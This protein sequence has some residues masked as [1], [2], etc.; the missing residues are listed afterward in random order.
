MEHRKN[1]HARFPGR[2]AARR[3][4]AMSSARI[5]IATLVPLF[6]LSCDH[7]VYKLTVSTEKDT[8][9]RELKLY[10]TDHGKSQNLTERPLVSKAYAAGEHSFKD[11]LHV[12]T[13]RFTGR[14]PQDI[15]GYGSFTRFSC[16]YGEVGLY[17]ER[18][19]GS[20]D[21]AANIA[22]RF[23]AV[24]RLTNLLLEWVRSAFGKSPDLF[25]L[26]CFIDSELRRDLKNA[27]VYAFLFVNLPSLAPES[28]HRLS[29]GDEGDGEKTV[30]AVTKAQI[31]RIAERQREELI[32]RLAFFFMERGYLE[33]CTMQYL[34]DLEDNIPPS[35]R[36]T[37]ILRV[38]E[39]AKVSDPAVRRKLC[40]CVADAN[41]LRESMSACLVK[42]P[43]YRELSRGKDVPPDPL[44]VPKNYFLQALEIN[45]ELWHEDDRVLLTVVPAG[46]VIRT[47]GRYDREKNVVTWRRDMGDRDVEPIKRRASQVCWALWAR[48]DETVQ[49]KHFGK[50]AIDGEDLLDYCMWHHRLSAR[51]RDEWDAFLE[52]LPGSAGTFRALDDFRFS[53]EPATPLDENG[54]PPRSRAWSGIHTVKDALAGHPATRPAR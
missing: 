4:N 10:N 7:D 38:L 52:N 49:R 21:F 34:W 2:C 9:V 26:W 41:K 39:R 48:P 19:R 11:G 16:P 37:I 23:D 8:I 33:P 17:G 18:F 1:S 44:D 31:H 13:G 27:A 24:D 14:T 6:C 35:L 32:P 46:R 43:E 54:R 30:P 12:F 45:F 3:E 28:S 25:R 20:N 5:I 53:D 51:R 50:I 29:G 47:N 42:T 15:G 36:E 40:A 22:L